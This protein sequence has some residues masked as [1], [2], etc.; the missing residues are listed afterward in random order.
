MH[1]TR[2]AYTYVYKISRSRCARV[3]EPTKFLDL[4]TPRGRLKTPETG[5]IRYF[6][7]FYPSTANQPTTKLLLLA[8]KPPSAFKFGDLGASARRRRADLTLLIR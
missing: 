2:D 1:F 8:L 6:H 5:E 4:Y 7:F 3:Y